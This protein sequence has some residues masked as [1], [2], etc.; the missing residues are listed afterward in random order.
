MVSAS[1]SQQADRRIVINKMPLYEGAIL[2]LDHHSDPI[3]N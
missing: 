1:I 3:V 2:C